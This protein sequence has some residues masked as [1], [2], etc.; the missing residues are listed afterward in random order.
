SAAGDHHCVRSP[1]EKTGENLT[2]DTQQSSSIE[3]HHAQRVL[4][5]SARVPVTFHGFQKG[6]RQQWVVLSRTKVGSQ[7]I[8]LRRPLVTTPNHSKNL[9]R[10][11][12]RQHGQGPCQ[13]MNIKL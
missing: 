7:K 8:D 5:A 10:C 9:F 1:A 4:P 3:G 11:L 13:C 2:S 6:N 12:C